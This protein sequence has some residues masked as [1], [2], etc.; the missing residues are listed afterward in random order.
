[1]PK[2]NHYKYTI[3]NTKFTNQ[4]HQYAVLSQEFFVANLRTFG[5]LLSG[6]ENAAVHQEWRISGIAWSASFIVWPIVL[7]AWHKRS[8][9]QIQTPQIIVGESRQ[10]GHEILTSGSNFD[11]PTTLLAPKE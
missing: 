7:P 5:V 3:Q 11:Y 4:V 1:M 2:S 8:T 6:L 10:S 9:Q